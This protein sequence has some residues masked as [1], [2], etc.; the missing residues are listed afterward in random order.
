MSEKEFFG[1][2]KK[3][4][5]ENY[6]RD[7]PFQHYTTGAESAI[8]ATIEALKEMMVGEPINTN[9]RVQ[10]EPLFIWDEDQ[11]EYV[12]LLKEGKQRTG[13]YGYIELFD[14]TVKDYPG[15]DGEEVII[16]PVRLS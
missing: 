3:Q 1:V 12:P 11:R 2:L 8:N 6:E 13:I 7:H 9:V 14:I 5:R 4:A 15:T 16:L 10:V